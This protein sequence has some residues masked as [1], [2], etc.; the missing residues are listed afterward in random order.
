MV[1]YGSLAI[2]RGLKKAL[3]SLAQKQIRPFYDE[4]G[5]GLS[6]LPRHFPK[7]LLFD[8]EFVLFKTV[9]SIYLLSKSCLHMVT[10]HHVAA[11]TGSRTVHS[12]V[13]NFASVVAPNTSRAAFFSSQV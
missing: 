6:L 3:L 9:L 5:A 8:L 10:P 2:L 13:W 4:H 12:I 1:A 11:M 7:P